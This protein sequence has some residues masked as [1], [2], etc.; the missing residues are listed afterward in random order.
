MTNTFHAT[1]YRN[2]RTQNMVNSIGI[3]LSRDAAVRI[4]R[5]MNV[6]LALLDANAFAQLT[7]EEN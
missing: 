7:E 4:V 3:G 5:D 1:I 2:D 6:A